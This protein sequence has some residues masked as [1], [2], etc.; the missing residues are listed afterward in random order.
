MLSEQDET[1]RSKDRSATNVLRYYEYYEYTYGAAA[2][3]YES[4]G[5]AVPCR[6]AIDQVAIAK[7]STRNAWRMVKYALELSGGVRT[8]SL[9]WLTVYANLIRE[10]SNVS[11]RHRRHHLHRCRRHHSLPATC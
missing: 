10:S 9:A 6:L 11:H 3:R 1:P 8:F 2:F 7:T 5:C 4:S